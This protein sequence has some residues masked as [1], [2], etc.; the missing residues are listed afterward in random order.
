LSE[1]LA[2]KAVRGA[3]WTI[4]ASIGSRAIGLIGTLVLTQFLPP[5]IQGE[6]SIAFILVL[7][8][9]TIAQQTGFGQYVVAKPREGRAAVFHATVYNLG[10]GVVAAGLIL[11][12]GRPLAPLFKAILG[13]RWGLGQVGFRWAI[14]LLVV[15]LAVGALAYVAAAFVFAP[16]TARELVRLVSKAILKRRGGGEGGAG[17]GGEGGTDGAAM[18]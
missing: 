7:S 18:A 15:E 3:A 2:H 6:V 11:L 16:A 13:T 17:A 12:F 10:F 8:A 5:E 9:N 4:L 14:P 1:E